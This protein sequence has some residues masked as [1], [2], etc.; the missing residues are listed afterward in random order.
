MSKWKTLSAKR[1]VELTRSVM[2]R[3]A[4]HAREKGYIHFSSDSPL[5]NKER[6]FTFDIGYGVTAIV[7]IRPSGNQDPQDT[8]LDVDLVSDTGGATL[9]ITS[10]LM[11]I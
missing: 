9:S 8:W 4:K 10:G 1:K 3:I 5:C 2:L 7:K 6:K 11:F